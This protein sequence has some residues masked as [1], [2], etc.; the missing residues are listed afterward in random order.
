MHYNLH[1]IPPLAT[2][3][4]SLSCYVD[5]DDFPIHPE[6]LNIAYQQVV[7]EGEIAFGQHE[8]AIRAEILHQIN[9]NFG[10]FGSRLFDIVDGEDFD[11]PLHRRC[12]EICDT[13]NL[14]LTNFRYLKPPTL[15]T[16]IKQDLELLTVSDI[17]KILKDNGHLTTGNREELVERLWVNLPIEQTKQMLFDKYQQKIE[18]YQKRQLKKKFELLVSY[19]KRRGYF[20]RYIAQNGGRIGF[21]SYLALVEFSTTMCSADDFILAKHLDGTGYDRVVVS[22]Q[23]NKLLPLFPYDF[24]SIMIK[25]KQMQ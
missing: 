6:I 23:I 7:Q 1:L 5:S 14:M 24:S 8:E 13:H 16:L 2:L 9:A 10:A 12:I 4:K 18:V 20:L 11:W 19:I 22:G 3:A 17:K 15:P 21:G 25:D